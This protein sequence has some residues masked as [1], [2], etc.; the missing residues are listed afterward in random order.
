MSTSS[1]CSL[2]PG[3]TRDITIVM[4]AKVGTPVGNSICRTLTVARQDSPTVRDVVKVTVRR[5]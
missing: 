2:A 5:R 4:K 3:A 1:S